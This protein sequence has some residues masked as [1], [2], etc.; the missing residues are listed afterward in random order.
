MRNIKKF[1]NIK[2]ITGIILIG[3]VGI[4]ST[5]L[6]G[7]VGYKDIQKMNDNISS[8]YSNDL[9]SIK[10][11]SEMLNSFQSIK[12]EVTKQ[13]KNYN[14][15][16]NSKI[17]LD[18]EKLNKNL[19]EYT[20]KNLSVTQKENVNKTISS[21][22][23][24]MSL[25]KE[26]KALFK[27]KQT[28]LVTKEEQ[29]YAQGDIT[30]DSLSKL[31][32][33]D[34]LNAEKEYY[35]SQKI[36]RESLTAF[37]SIV[38]ISFLVL[39]AIA[40]LI[41]TIVKK[42][43]KEIINILNT[44]AQGNLNINLNTESN[45]EFGM[46]KRALNTTIKNISKM[47]LEIKGKSEDINKSSKVLYSISEEM[48]VSANEVAS[49]IQ[50]TAA[51]SS[52]QAGDLIDISQMLSK[53]NQSIVAMVKS[54]EDV[55]R[56]SNNIEAMTEKG[57]KNIQILTES[58]DKVMKSSDDFTIS[59]SKFGKNIY[60]INEITNIIN[61]IANQTNLL[62]LNAS[63]EAARSGE[64]GK[65]FSVVAEE[66]K[67]LA[68]ESK[69]SS[70]NISKLI[71]ELSND[72]KNVFKVANTMDNELSNQKEVTNN[73]I[74][75]F[76]KIILAVNDN[77][78]KIQLVTTFANNINKEKD[79][80][81]KKVENSS[82]IAEEISAS[83]EEI[84]SSSEEMNACAEEVSKAAQVLN[85]IAKETMDKLNEFKL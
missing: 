77:T 80:I 60:Q 34:N 23:S 44:I 76:E 39:A 29:I 73:I 26:T 79:Y 46:M 50:E 56:N 66:I 27:S 25:W 33:E 36:Y 54:I 21:L 71:S 78:P 16:A 10:K 51:G 35:K 59:F 6:I 85:N 15:K 81:L 68:E 82:S 55:D 38:S 43:S 30:T 53:F 74:D 42:S 72:T 40:I 83:S 5:S 13:M 18:Y 17:D 32:Y 19:K 57:E 12:V 11:E 9:D 65:G 7:I 48:T 61:G 22:N 2:I 37:I 63:I 58:I 1:K 45:N 64:H 14:E 69:I 28:L 20:E 62:A 52:H 41:I 70:E 49:S 24:Y 4:V 3:I 84:S 75:S 31:I 47:I 8:I 67:K